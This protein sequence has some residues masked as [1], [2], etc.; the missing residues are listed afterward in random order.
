[1]PLN[2]HV[3]QS[4][5]F[6]SVKCVGEIPA[7]SSCPALSVRGSLRVQGSSQPFIRLRHAKVA[8][9]DAGS[10]ICGVAPRLSSSP[11]RDASRGRAQ[12]VRTGASNIS[13]LMLF[14]VLA[15]GY[16]LCSVFPG[17]TLHS[18]GTRLGEAFFS[19]GFHQRRGVVPASSLACPLI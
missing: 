2:S 17:L 5:G 14:K 9:N 15:G 8:S 16:V 19:H 4:S 1:M 11:L 6:G 13:L 10:P 7:A 12:R 18:R 3:R